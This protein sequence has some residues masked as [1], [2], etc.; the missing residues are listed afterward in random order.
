MSLAPEEGNWRA[1]SRI[2]ARRVLEHINRVMSG[3]GDEL[4]G[5]AGIKPES[6]SLA[7]GAQCQTDF[8]A[9]RSTLSTSR[10]SA[11]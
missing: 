10:N 3:A 4:H 7:N 5:A 6:L 2:L 9:G 8:T 11:L 1:A